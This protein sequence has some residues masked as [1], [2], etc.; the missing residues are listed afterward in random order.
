LTVVPTLLASHPADCW[1]AADAGFWRLVLCALSQLHQR[2]A[3]VSCC[4]ATDSPLAPTPV[5]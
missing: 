4:A 1:Q 5:Q 3:E 2:G